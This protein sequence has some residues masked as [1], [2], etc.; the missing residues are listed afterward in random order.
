[1]AVSDIILDD[2]YDLVIE[3]GDFKVSDSDNQH[4]ELLCITA[5]GH[6]KQHPLIGVGITQYIASSGQ[7]DALKRIINIQLSADGYLVNQV[8]VSG[9]NETFTYSIDAERN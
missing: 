2:N 8:L 1:M 9:L 6:W 5:L 7:S 4:I 3:N